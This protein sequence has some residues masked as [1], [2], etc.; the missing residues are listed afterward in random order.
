VQ[1]CFAPGGC[2]NKRAARTSRCRSPAWAVHPGT[3]LLIGDIDS[4]VRVQPLLSRLHAQHD[5]ETFGTL[6]N[7]DLGRPFRRIARRGYGHRNDIRGLA[8]TIEDAVFTD[9]RRVA[10]MN[11]GGVLA[12]G[13]GLSC[14][15]QA[16]VGALDLIY[17]GSFTRP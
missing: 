4:I 14:K 5:V 12:G 8:K 16:G 9:D 15:L 6:R 10:H 13:G 11:V 17:Q 1:F 3:K 2:I 7:R